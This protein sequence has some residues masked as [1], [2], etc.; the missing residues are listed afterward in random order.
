MV[1]TRTFFFHTPRR[2]SAGVVDRLT[3]LRRVGGA[4]IVAAL[5][6]AGMSTLTA[7]AARADTT[8]TNKTTANGLGNNVVYGVYAVGSTVYAATDGGLS[9]STDGGTSF[10]NKTTADGLGND[11]LY[12]VY[13][14]GS[15]IYA[16]GR[17]LSISTNGGASFTNYTTSNSLGSNAVNGVY[18]VGSTIY[19]A[20]AGGLSISTNGGTSFTNKT[21]LNGLGDT[22]LYGVYAVGSTVYAAT[23]GGLSISINGGSTFT[24]K[25]TANGL[26]NNWCYGV[27]AIGSTVYAATLGGLSISTD[28][29]STF[30]NYRTA[31]GLGSSYVFGVFASGSTVYAATYGGVSI[32][33]DG[34]SQNNPSP[35]VPVVTTSPVTFRLPDGRECT[36]ISPQFVIT[37]SNYQLPG[38][39]ANCRTPGSVIA[40]WSIPGQDW[41]FGPSGIVNVTAAQT[42]TA[43]LREPVVRI[44]LDAN[45]AA[46]D[47]CTVSGATSAASV[48]VDQRAVTLFL[49]RK[50]MTT[51]GRPDQPALASF[52]APAIAVC[53]PPG[54]RLV[55]WSASGDGKATRTDV[56]RPFEPVI[57]DS[58]NTIR[59]F[60]VWS[61]A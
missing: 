10:T 15:T 54:Y 23:A 7:P 39:Q 6:M 43:V 18:A 33:A 26:G 25:T 9:I 30:T 46:S 14:V 8:F 57:G 17:G 52:P 50:D 12:G 56:G 34:G 19:A 58:M 31:S 11:S 22:S 13:A 3:A 40:G 53:T 1:T 16:A 35:D 36:S 59:F 44:V 20:T 5:V 2:G 48:S 4:A 51:P 38:E 21:T 24:N 27:Y 49:Q 45:V 29:G 61:A 42:F 32:S 28:G 55:G 60:A 41:A 37:N 47:A